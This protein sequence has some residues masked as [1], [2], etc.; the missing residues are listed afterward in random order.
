MTIVRK[1]CRLANLERIINS[2][3]APPEVKKISNLL[4]QDS[5]NPPQS[6]AKPV[7]AG[8]DTYLKLLQYLN[9][10]NPHINWVDFNQATSSSAH[11]HEIV[12]P[13]CWIYHKSVHWKNKIFTTFEKHPGNSIISYFWSD[14]CHFGTIKSIVTIN[15]PHQNLNSYFF[16]INPFLTNNNFLLHWPNLNI[17]HVKTSTE[18]IIITCNDIDGHCAFYTDTSLSLLTKLSLS[19]PGF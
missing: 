19:P 9:I 2:P 5:S 6:M 11:S 12:I 13:P 8:R 3:E 15:D 7:L 14:V 4:A 18:N 16:V 17:Y 1:F 10:K